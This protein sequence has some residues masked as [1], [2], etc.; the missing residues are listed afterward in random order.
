MASETNNIVA[1]KLHIWYHEGQVR[2]KKSGNSDDSELPDL[3]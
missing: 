3:L 2:K 1:E